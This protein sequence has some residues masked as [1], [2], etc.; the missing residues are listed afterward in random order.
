MTVKPLSEHLRD[1]LE[2]GV[3]LQIMLEPDVSPCEFPDLSP[4]T[5]YHHG[6]RCANCVEAKKAVDVEY[7]HAHREQI[8]A[9]ARLKYWRQSRR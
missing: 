1:L 2:A 3:P 4:V 6:C 9:T 5:A 8:N 7:R